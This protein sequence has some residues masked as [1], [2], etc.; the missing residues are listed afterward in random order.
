MNNKLLATAAFVSIALGAYSAPIFTVLDL[1]SSLLIQNES[2]KDSLESDSEI[3]LALNRPKSKKSKKEV[4]EEDDD[5]DELSEDAEKVLTEDTDDD[6]DD[7]DDGEGE[8]DDSDDDDD[9]DYTEDDSDDDDD[10]DYTEDG[11][12][13][14]EPSNGNGFGDIKSQLD[15]KN[16]TLP[17]SK[18]DYHVHK[19][20]PHNTVV[21]RLDP[22][23]SRQ[24][25]ITYL[26]GDEI[27]L[28]HTITFY[29]N[30]SY[31]I[32]A[33]VKS[34]YKTI[35]PPTVVG[36]T[37]QYANY[38]VTEFSIYNGKIITT[39]TLTPQRNGMWKIDYKWKIVDPNI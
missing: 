5:D 37:K 15:N 25:Y 39:F 8:G 19:N 14:A 21:N 29:P 24:E 17:E 28:K 32:N 18:S 10:G 6:S 30:G 2:S 27:T 13:N 20:A 34:N 3:L 31:Y 12:E 7:S 1:N 4:E 16:S 38:S 35:T 22:Q 11:D 26:Y 23:G 33:E 9:G 36:N